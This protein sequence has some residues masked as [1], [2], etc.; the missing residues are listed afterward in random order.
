MDLA[1]A[2]IEDDVGSDV[3]PAV[4]EELLGRGSQSQFS[5]PL[6]SAQPQTDQGRQS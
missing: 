3:A 2:L 6:W 1:L 5:V 4:A